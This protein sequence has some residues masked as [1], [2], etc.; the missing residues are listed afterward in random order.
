MTADGDAPRTP[1]FETT[2]AGSLPKPAWLAE[3]NKLWPQWQ[4]R[5]LRARRRQA[6]CH[7]AR[8]EAAGGRRHRHRHRRRAVA[9]AFRPR[10]SR[11]R[12]RASTSPT[13]SKWAS[14]TT[15]T[16][17]WCRR[18]RALRL[19]GPRAS[20]PRPARARPHHAQAQVHP[21]GP[22]DDRRHHRRRPLRRPRQ[23]GDGVRRAYSM[24]RRAR[25]KPTAST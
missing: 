25:S 15:A 24:P 9:P 14:A 11:V 12:R 13:R 17:R 2:I 23:D 1:M 20:R 21:A 22:D 4:L 5:R 18:H 19:Q 10:L 16:R 3:P 8:A 6:R 7:A